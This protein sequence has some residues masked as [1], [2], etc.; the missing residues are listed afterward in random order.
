MSWNIVITI[1]AGI[2]V[3]DLHSSIHHVKYTHN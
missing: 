3:E 2:F 1:R